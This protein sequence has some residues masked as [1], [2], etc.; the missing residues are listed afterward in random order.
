MVTVSV[1]MSLIFRYLTIQ[2]KITSMYDNFIAN[3][4]HE[5]KSPLASIQLYIETL[6][7]RKVP[8]TRQEE[9]LSIMTKDSE[10]LQNLIDTILKVS[11]LEQEKF[12]YNYQVVA[13]GPTFQKLMNEVAEQFKLPKASITLSGKTSHLCIIDYN[14]MRT[15]LDNLANNTI[16]YSLDTPKISMTISSTA[17]HVQ[18]EFR[19]FGI[20][21]SLKDQKQI[22]KKFHRIYRHDMPNVK[23]TGL[24]LYWVKKIIKAHDGKISVYSEGRGKGTTFLIELPIYL[25]TKRRH[26]NRLLKIARN[27]KNLEEVEYES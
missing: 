19:D 15:V 2:L 5:L 10:R 24:G 3:V 20:G 22:F 7:A 21:I 1:A 26:I 25:R 13:S 9:F 4:T 27:R 6:K 17:T 18:I 12:V 14:A 23:G 16:K 11:G 8:H